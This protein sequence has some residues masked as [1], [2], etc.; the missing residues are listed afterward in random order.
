MALLRPDVLVLAA[1]GVVGEAWMTGLL[2]GVEAEAGLDF[3]EVETFLGTSAGS[4]VAASLA[5]GRRPRRPADGDGP[6]A[7]EAAF[8]GGEDG[9]TASPAAGIARTAARWGGAVAAPFAPVALRVGAPGGALAR[10]TA[11]RRL[12]AGRRS[13]ARLR[14]EVDSWRARF[15]GR[16][17]I[18]AV[19]SAAGRRAVFGAPGAPSANVGEAVEASC[20]VP[21]VFRPVTIGGRTYVDGGAWSLTNLDAAPAA[22]D[23]RV[24]CLTVTGGRAAPSPAG[25]LRAAARPAVALEATALRRRGAIVDVVGPEHDI[26]ANLLDPAAA[27]AAL[28]AG[29]AQGRRLATASG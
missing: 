15:D 20:A 1:G 2:A 17:R 5:A 9:A 21:A 23:T 6:S 26:G 27:P 18:C 25:L 22:R 7:E 14:S 12:P 16:L 29:F 4:I 3:R 10:R 8:D 28:A 24:L 11:L 19:D 13:L